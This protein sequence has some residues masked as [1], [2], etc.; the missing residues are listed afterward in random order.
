MAKRTRDNWRR[1]NGLW[2]PEHPRALVPRGMG[3]LPATVREW[4]GGCFAGCCEGPLCNC[5]CANCAPVNGQY[6]NTAPCCWRVSISGMA[7]DTCSTCE[8]FNGSWYLSQDAEN[9]CTW[10]V[11][12]PKGC[13]RCDSVDLVLTVYED[14]GDYKIKV[15]MI[16]DADAVLHKWEKS[17]GGTKPDCCGLE[18]TL[19][20]VTNDGDCDSA[21]AVCSI[22]ST[23]TDPDECYA[24][25]EDCTDACLDN[26]T[27]VL[28]Q[29]TI[30][31]LAN[32]SEC[33]NCQLVDGTYTL[34][35]QGNCRWAYSDNTNYCNIPRLG[36]GGLEVAFSVGTYE[37]TYYAT[38]DIGHKTCTGTTAQIG[39]RWAIWNALE[40]FDCRNLNIQDEDWTQRVTRNNGCDPSGST[41][42]V[43]VL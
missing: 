28:L 19:S 40:K 33:T 10:S 23:D 25:C 18:D 38:L 15:E 8:K 21:S 26:Y 29:V 43:V 1:G 4:G 35:Y 3:R 11:R 17:Y 32:A 37:G 36:C 42:T 20:L 9:G 2:L 31:G 5:N 12:I 13:T 30:S 22:A 41:A 39:A 24:E 34:E 14:A 16:D 27:P 7:D 6:I